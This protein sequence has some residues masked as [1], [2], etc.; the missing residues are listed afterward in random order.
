MLRLVLGHVIL[1]TTLMGAHALKSEPVPTTRVSYADLD[2]GRADDRAR[3]ESRLDRAAR[4]VCRT[5]GVPGAREAVQRNA[6]IA[7]SRADAERQ[8]AFAV[9]GTQV[10]AVSPR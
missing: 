4:Q 9:A 7:A 1:A 3:L 8:M 6:C 2:L 10:A 5:N